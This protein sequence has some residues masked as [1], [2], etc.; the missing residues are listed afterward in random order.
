[1]KRFLAALAVAC[2][3]TPALAQQNQPVCFPAD[4][5]LQSLA[6]KYGEVPAV[7][8]AMDTGALMVIVA[9]DKTGSWSL[10]IHPPG[11]EDILCIGMTGDGWS[12]GKDT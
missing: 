2:L 11:K 6:D 3:C 5:V 10:L 12:P 9:N 8:G 4:I 7:M 1:M